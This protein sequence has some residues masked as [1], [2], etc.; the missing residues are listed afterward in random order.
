MSPGRLP[1]PSAKNTVGNRI[2]FDQIREQ[3]VLWKCPSAPT[4]CRQ[5]RSRRTAPRTPPRRARSPHQSIGR[6]VGDQVVQ[7]RR[8]KL[9]GDREPGRIHERV[10]VDQIGDVL[11]GGGSP[12]A[13]RRGHRVGRRLLVIAAPAAQ[14]RQV[15]SAGAKGFCQTVDGKKVSRPPPVTKTRSCHHRRVLRGGDGAAA[16]WLVWGSVDRPVLADTSP[17][18]WIATWSSSG[19]QPIYRNSSFYDAYW[20]VIPP[21]MLFYS[22]PAAAPTRCVAG[23]CDRWLNIRL[24]GNWRV[25]LSP[26]CI[27]RTALSDAAGNDGRVPGST[28]SSVPDAAGV[29]RHDPAYV[30]VTRPILASAGD[31][32]CVR[33]GNRRRDNAS[34]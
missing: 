9:C 14:P 4:G 10:R 17:P 34:I 21:L 7:S 1:P 13:C 15:R 29:H 8:W 26:V 16:I 11:P 28:C 23:C 27:T 32:A 5:H 2:R 18:T 25:R 19:V 30:A 6:G 31:V 3:P 24:T 33:H 12:A 20:S 22:G